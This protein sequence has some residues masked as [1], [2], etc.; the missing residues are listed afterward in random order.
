VP[1]TPRKRKGSS[2]VSSP[3]DTEPSRQQREIAAAEAA[4]YWPGEMTPD[5]FAK[6]KAAAFERPKRATGVYVSIFAPRE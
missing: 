3:G 6:A 1:T 4:T 5:E 2:P